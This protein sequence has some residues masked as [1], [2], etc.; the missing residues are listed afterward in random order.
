MYVCMY[1][2]EA[3]MKSSKQTD[4]TTREYISLL[5]EDIKFVERLFGRQKKV[6][7]T[8]SIGK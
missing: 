2:W 4:W 5:E 3:V 1:V 6:G 7:S 8:E